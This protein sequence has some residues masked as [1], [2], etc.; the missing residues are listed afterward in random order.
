VGQTFLGIDIGTSK[1]AAVILDEAG[2]TRGVASVLHG[3]DIPAGPGRSEQDPAALFGSIVTALAMLGPAVR[4]VAAVGVT[5]QMHGVMLLNAEGEPVGPLVTWQDGRCLEGAFLD[6]LNGRTGAALRS[7]YGCATL[8]WYA[9]NGL[10]PRGAAAAS[11]VHDWVAS[12]ICGLARP[13][14]DPTDAHS[15]GLFELAAQDWDHRAVAAAGFPQVLLPRLVPCGAAIGAVSAAAAAALGLPPG[16]PVAAALGDNQASLLA[17]LGDPDTDLA[18][19]LGTGGQLSAVQPAGASP[20]PLPSGASWEYRPYLDGRLLAAAASLCGG[21]AWR[22]LAQ[23]AG[24]WLADLGAAAPAD[25]DLFAKLNQ[26]AESGAGGLTVHPHF[27]GERHDPG[28]RGS[29]EGITSG[30]FSLGSLARALAEGICANL[31]DMMPP[32]LRKG[33]TRIVASGNALA[34]NPALRRAAQD[35]FGLPVHMTGQAESAAVGAARL[36]SRMVPPYT[37]AHLR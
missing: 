37:P 7:G 35:V 28:L 25:D 15:W 20:P 23:A 32:E 5:G 9:A 8:S 6:G 34:R 13:V 27:L 33:R 21:S 24:S 3:A 17:T 14:T 19:T 30:N 1:T 26:L 22:W 4:Q 11:T 18:L 10:L 12:R 29:V 16:I 2:Q 31:R 36:A